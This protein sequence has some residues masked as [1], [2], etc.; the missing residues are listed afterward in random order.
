MNRFLALA[1]L[2]AVAFA[3]REDGDGG[4]GAANYGSY[5]TA[6]YGSYN[7][8]S[9]T[10]VVSSFVAAPP[11][12]STTQMADD[13]MS[14]TPAISPVA[15]AVT[16]AASAAPSLITLSLVATPTAAGLPQSP[17]ATHTV[18]EDC[19]HILTP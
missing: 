1:A 4:W 11:M 6:N 9:P 15:G 13:M 7:Y 10:A 16:S 18:S 14:S 12:P 8:G 3:G 17:V 5:S 19:P 2:F